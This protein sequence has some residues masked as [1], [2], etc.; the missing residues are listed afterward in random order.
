MKR[1]RKTI[2]HYYEFVKM[3]EGVLMHTNLRSGYLVKT[4]N[5][6]SL[7]VRDFCGEE[8]EIQKEQIRNTELEKK[9]E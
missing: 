6:G 7:V 8:T 4:L 9:G 3:Y 1:R 2:V 5:D